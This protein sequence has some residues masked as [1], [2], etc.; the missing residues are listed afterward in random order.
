MRFM[1]FCCS[2]ALLFA[3]LAMHAQGTSTFQNLDFESA[4]VAGCSPGQVVPIS[5]AMPGWSANLDQVYYDE[6]SI[7]G[8]LISVIDSRSLS[9][10]APL[11]GSYSV[12]LFGQGGTFPAPVSISQMGLVPAGTRSVVVDMY[13][14]FATPVVMLGGQTIAMVPIKTFPTYTLYAGDVSSFAGQTATLSFTAP[15]AAVGSPSI[16]ELDNIIFSRAAVPEPRELPLLM[17]GGLF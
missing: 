6:E 15:P 13:W 10:L 9:G 17:M 8:A 14:K 11:Q 4:N 7:G 5:L 1:K 16:I 2:L 12:L 3:P